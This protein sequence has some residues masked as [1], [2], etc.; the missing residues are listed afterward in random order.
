MPKLTTEQ[1]SG[2]KEMLKDK[3]RTNADIARNAGVDAC[4]VATL[5]RKFVEEI[6]GPFYLERLQH[7][8]AE[9]LSKIAQDS[10]YDP[11]PETTKVVNDKEI[12][13]ISKSVLDQHRV[14]LSSKSKRGLNQKYNSDGRD[15]HG[16]WV[17]PRDDLYETSKPA[18]DKLTEQMEQDPTIMAKF[19]KIFEYTQEV[20]ATA[21][22]RAEERKSGVHLSKDD[23]RMGDG[24]RRHL[25]WAVWLDEVQK[26][27]AES[28]SD[29]ARFE[30]ELKEAQTR[31]G[32]F[33][34]AAESGS[35]R[36]TR[37]TQNTVEKH[38]TTADSEAGKVTAAQ[39]SSYRLL[40]DAVQ[41]I[42]V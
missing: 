31:L 28:K 2:I 4:T 7:V 35:A 29:V 12:P 1:V 26:R 13:E 6:N 14:D 9:D 20:K 15:F 42:C 21:E 8:S 17:C 24:K 41:C 19:T 5:K 39:K 27:L 22:Q 32:A 34:A 3:A 11:A 16:F 33:S 40:A 30:K 18:V 10:S 36:A 37:G 38:A 23:L 25:V